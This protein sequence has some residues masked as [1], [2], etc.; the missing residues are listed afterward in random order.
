MTNRTSLKKMFLNYKAS[1]A[2]NTFLKCC[3]KNKS[4]FK[5]QT[6]AAVRKPIN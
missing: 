3:T 6:A 1:H 5:I 4:N 2:S